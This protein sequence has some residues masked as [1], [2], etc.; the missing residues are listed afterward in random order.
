MI[1]INDFLGITCDSR[2]VKTGFVF[3]AVR[4]E[5]LNGEDFIQS[6]IDNGCV[7][8][9]VRNDYENILFDEN[10]FIRTN[11]V[12][13][14]QAKFSTLIYKNNLKNTICV[15]GTNGKTSVSNFVFDM[16][17]KIENVEPMV[18]GTI[19]IKS[20]KYHNPK[21]LTTPDACDLMENI[22]NRCDEGVNALVIEASSHGLDMHRLDGLKPNCAIFT[23]FTNDHLDYH[24]TV[25]NYRNSKMY[26]FNNLL[27]DDGIKIVH[28]SVENFFT[29]EQK[30]KNFYT[31]DLYDNNC[32][33]YCEKIEYKNFAYHLN[34]NFFGINIELK[35]D[36][37]GEFQ[38]LNLLSSLIIIN[39]LYNIG[40]DEFQKYIN[41][42][43][44]VEGRMEVVEKINGSIIVVDFSHTPD[45]LEKVLK[46]FS[47][48]KEINNIDCVFGCGGD[49]D[50]TKRPLMGEIAQKYCD[51]V[52]I[53]DDNPR[54][55][56]PEKIRKQILEKCEKGIEIEGR[57][58]AIE[59]AI[60][61][62]QKNSVL[63]IAGKGHEKY[64]II[65][66]KKHYFSDQEVVR[67]YI[68][69]L[70]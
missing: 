33:V 54:F 63:M 47:K 25:E 58:K 60:D 56:N 70:V 18:V 69:C 34:L 5:E 29:A 14:E 3:V 35:F 20:K 53:T 15:T 40:V 1:D 28:N 7:K 38:I 42:I 36:I 39:K 49:R 12:R 67:E 65:G 27:C 17:S 10:M 43:N 13:L 11:N 45:G 62:L 24:G 8:I 52:V 21:S 55:E 31:Y 2:K 51:N 16:L 4:G 41:F 22:S 50:V 30:L 59:Y 37:F 26:L 32:D 48:D 57:K 68:K 44:P 64:Q 19:G 23:N 6:A 66:D 46:E 61:N 9:I